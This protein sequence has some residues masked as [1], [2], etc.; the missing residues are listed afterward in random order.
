MSKPIGKIAAAANQFA[1]LLF[2]KSLLNVV[3]GI[4]DGV[5]S[6]RH[7][8]LGMFFYNLR[9]CVLA[10][11]AVFLLCLAWS[12][13]SEITG[14][15]FILSVAWVATALA[16]GIRHPRFCRSIDYWASKPVH[17]GLPELFDF[18]FKL[19]LGVL[20]GSVLSGYVLK[21]PLELFS[22]LAL[23]EA[24][25]YAAYV[26]G[27]PNS[28]GF[29]GIGWPLVLLALVPIVVF[30]RPRH[31]LSAMTWE[32]TLFNF[33]PLLS[34]A[35]VTVLCVAVVSRLHASSV[36]VG[37]SRLRLL[38][39]CQQKALSRI[40][41]QQLPDYPEGADSFFRKAMEHMLAD[42]CAIREAL[43]YRSA[44][45][46]LV[47]RH[48]KRGLVL[49][50]RAIVNCHLSDEYKSNG[51]DWSNLSLLQTDITVIPR[52]KL[53]D[54]TANQEAALILPGELA[55]QA[56]NKPLALVPL[57][58]EEQ[59]IGVLCLFGDQE[60]PPVRDDEVSFLLSLRE[61]VVTAIHAWG[62]RAYAR[63][64]K[65]IRLLDD[66][67]TVE[68]LLTRAAIVARQ[69]EGAVF[70]VV[71]YET[72]TAGV[73]GAVAQGTDSN[74]HRLGKVRNANL[75][76]FYR[77]DDADI[78]RPALPEMLKSWLPLLAEVPQ[79]LLALPIPAVKGGVLVANREWRTSWFT[80]RDCRVAEGLSRRLG[81]RISAFEHAAAVDRA[82]R[83]A[84][85]ERDKAEEA[86]ANATVQTEEAQRAHR[87]ADRA[88][89]EAKQKAAEASQAQLNAEDAAR[90]RELDLLTLTHQLYGPLTAARM[91][92]TSLP[93]LYR[94]KGEAPLKLAAALIEDVM[95]ISY[96]TFTALGRDSR[97]STLEA[98]S[99]NDPNPQFTDVA[100]NPTQ[101][102]RKLV[103]RLQQTNP[104]GD[105]EF[106]FIETKTFPSLVMDKRVF[107]SVLYSLI[108]NALKYASS[109]STV[110]LKCAFDD[111]TARPVLKVESRGIHIQ[112]HEAELVFAKFGRG[113]LVRSTGR[114][115][116]GT[117]VGLWAARELMQAVGGDLTVELDPD[118]PAL[119]VF[120]VQFPRI[121]AAASART[122]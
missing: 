55:A 122:E 104:R 114:H 65:S 75:A 69:L 56:A 117:G 88:A 70:S 81:A 42:L 120:V 79:G 90:Q 101:E 27:R 49:L 33:F 61:I 54:Q 89:I 20:A 45:L 85:E 5:E 12:A 121:A 26:T 2:R 19:D 17:S 64:Q 10:I 94:N 6:L 50:P 63:A 116:H 52:F 15:I 44:C 1:R 118:D 16:T 78:S 11:G 22:L 106:S 96:G 119:S 59:L 24:I 46:L 93:Y 41:D 43:C 100:I 68:G 18:Y 80:D 40:H 77:C 102:L 76:G 30:S 13:S 25:V 74:I 82:L 4:E 73:I 29:S 62:D 7:N 8:P 48:S 58:R 103:L 86:S 53:T 71:W 60:S 115:H 72:D 108:H 97:R 23:S 105:L 39:L 91:A 57:K 34:L 67:T 9:A 107:V 14:A 66:E 83:T 112:A 28:R 95:D 51:I 35:F 110:E 21:I 84:R 47:E 38:A 3:L 31:V 99:S 98:A 92:I 113:Y 109:G 32:E 87:A 111:L 37:Q 36:R